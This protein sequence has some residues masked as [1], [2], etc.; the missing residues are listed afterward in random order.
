MARVLPPQKEFQDSDRA[1]LWDAR[2]ATTNRAR[3]AGTSAT[4]GVALAPRSV[5][6][7]NPAVK[8]V[9]WNLA[10]VG[11]LLYAF[12]EY[13]RLPEM[14]PVL[15]TFHL[16]EAVLVLAAV[17]YLVSPRIRSSSRSASRSIDVAVFIFIAGNVLSTCFAPAQ[18]HVWYGLVIV[19][20]SG[21]IY[22]LMS[23]IL[24]NVWQIRALLFLVLLLNLKFA[25]HTIRSYLFYRSAGVS[26]MQIYMSG[27]AGEGRT[28]YFGNVADLGL[29]MG[30]VWGIV[31]SLLAGKPKMRKSSRI[32]LLVC[33]AFYLLAILVCGSRGA[34]V[35]ATAIVLV[36]LRKSAKKISAVLL[37]IVFLLGLWF[38]MPNATRERF[39]SAMDWQND[40]NA[41]SRIMFW[42][43]GIDMFGHNPILGVGPGNFAEVNP[44][45]YVA[46]SL[47]IQVLAESGLV[48][49]ISLAVILFLFF[50]LNARTRKLALA[51]PG[52]AGRK[53]FEYR[54]AF[55]LDLGMVGF[56]TSGAFL[57]VLYYPHLWVLLGLSVAV[58]RCC[59]KGQTT[60]EASVQAKPRNFAS[61]S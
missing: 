22:L 15:Q 14:Y 29:A 37:V 44:Y 49:T 17:G 16:G 27:G 46:H 13:S 20:Y 18:E 9:R 35:G 30:V 24:V 45:H 33:F 48:G 42:G 31:W 43:I 2:R 61:V 57:S 12:V 47:Y 50:R 40:P 39:H 19:L 32:F 7:A 26:A 59:I 53:S 4:N 38:V 3:F 60:G 23:R 41:S 5:S 36:A 10:F 21:V 25:Q 51:R 56:L 11:L 55:G 6:E 34:I 1:I 54:L 28:S 58:N 8:D 52:A